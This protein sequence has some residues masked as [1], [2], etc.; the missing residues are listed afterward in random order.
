[1]VDTENVVVNVLGEDW[2]IIYKDE[3]PAF[4]QCGGYCDDCTRTIVIENIKIGNDPLSTSPKGQLENQK[5]IIRHELIHAF[6]SESGLSD[7]SFETEAWA[8]NEEMVDW[9]ARQ[10][11][12]IFKI[13]KELKII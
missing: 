8:N 13:Y 11:P 5:R 12:K 7:S 6:L 4:E 10:S 2:T 1:M 9:F 3:D